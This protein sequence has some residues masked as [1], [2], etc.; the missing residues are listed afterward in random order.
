MKIAILDY[1]AGNLKSISNACK[2][3]GVSVSI[4]SKYQANSLKDFDKIILPGVGNF[5]NAMMKLNEFKEILLDKIGDGVPFLGLCLGIQV[6]FESSE[7]SP[8]TKGLGIFKGSCVKFPDTVKIP[9]TGWNNIKVIKE[10]PILRD[11]PSGSYF[12]FV[13]SYYP[14]PKEREIVIA[15]TNYGIEFPS[16]VSKDNIFATQFHPEKSNSIGLKILENFLS[17]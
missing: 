4:V 14:V 6:I 9:H 17:L 15:T 13:H 3:L 5:G 11:I 8:E 2:K 7:E 12:Y 10:N 16:V 1:G